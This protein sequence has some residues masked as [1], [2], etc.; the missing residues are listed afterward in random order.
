VES[1]VGE[2]SIVRQEFHEPHQFSFTKELEDN[3]KTIKKE[4]DD[5]NTA[6]FHPWPEANLFVKDGNRGEGWDVFGLYA[7]GKKHHRNIKLCPETARIVEKIPGLSTAAFSIL[8]PGAKILPHVGY[9]G[10]SEMVLRCH[11]GLYVP[12]QEDC[13]LHVGEKRQSWEE[14]K[15][16][17]F[18]DTYVHSAVNLSNITRVILLLDFS[19]GVPVPAHLQKK[20]DEK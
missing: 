20:L 3:W 14:G 13:W 6:L 10:Y 2:F 5:L 4:F 18:D 15:C 12:P 1:F 8:R 11:L 9:Y 17:V 16:M 19:T 7:F